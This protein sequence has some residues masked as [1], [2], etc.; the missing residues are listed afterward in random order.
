MKG[1]HAHRFRDTFAVELLLNG[2]PIENVAAFLGHA[3]TR[4][5]QKHYSAW[6]HTRQE[7]AETDVKRSWERDP[8]VLM[9]T[10]GTQEVYGNV[11]TVN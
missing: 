11:R 1:D 7:Q 8:V 4:I 9:E 5:T 2:T 3:S 6:V 10:K